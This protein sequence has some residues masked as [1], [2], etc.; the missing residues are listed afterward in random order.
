MVIYLFILLTV[1]LLALS[2]SKR[3]WFSPTTL[4]KQLK[5]FA[6]ASYNL[7]YEIMK[8]GNRGGKIKSRRQ[9][10]GGEMRMRERGKVEVER[11]IL[12]G[13]WIM[14]CI[15]KMMSTGSAAN[16]SSQSDRYDV[17]FISNAGMN[18]S[19]AK[20]RWEKYRKSTQV[21]ERASRWPIARVMDRIGQWCVSCNGHGDCYSDGIVSSIHLRRTPP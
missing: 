15:N 12:T 19:V 8:H 13:S 21:V 6:L 10:E 14:M 7:A 16:L 2:N 18:R 5:D 17:A 4:R 11:F 9:G 1:I 3:N 20:A